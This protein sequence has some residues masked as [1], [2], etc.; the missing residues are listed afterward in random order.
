MSDPKKKIGQRFVVSHRRSHHL[1]QKSGLQGREVFE[2]KF[3]SLQSVVDIL[4]DQV[5]GQDGGRRIYMVEGDPREIQGKAAELCP[6]TIIEPELPRTVTRSEPLAVH[7]LNTL[8]GPIPVSPGQGA[9]LELRLRCGDAPL[10]GAKVILYLAALQQFGGA[11]STSIGGHTDEEGRVILGYDPA[12]WTPTMAMIQP[13]GDAWGMLVQQQGCTGQTV[14]VPPLPR[15]GPLGWWHLLVGATAY[16]PTLGAGISV[17]VIDTGAGPHP[18]LAHVRRIGAFLDCGSDTSD[19]AGLDVEMH[20][21]HVSGIIGAR[22][23]EGSGDYA[24]LAPGVDLAVARVFKANG[25]ANQGDIAAAVE[26][27]SC[28]HQVDLI[29]LSLGGSPSLIERDALT[30][31][32]MKGT[33]CIAAAGNKHGAPV[34][35]PAAYPECVAVS[36]VELHGFAPTGTLASMNL[37]Q[38]PDRFSPYGAYLAAFSN[39]GPQIEITAPGGGILSTAP[40]KPDQAQAPYVDMSGTSMASP[41]V[42]AA[43]AVLLSEDPM[44]RSLPRGLARATY[45]RSILFANAITLGLNPYYQGVGLVRQLRAGGWGQ[46]GQWAVAPPPPA[47]QGAGVEAAEPPPPAPTAGTRRFILAPKSGANALPAEVLLERIG[48][49]PGVSVVRRQ[50]ERVLVDATEEGLRALHRELGA[51]FFIEEDSPRHLAP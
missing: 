44:Y 37:P 14:Q 26:A 39:L 9:R 15:K 22:P 47:A 17:G 11:Q 46:Q 16:K 49:I 41:L 4:S 12:T 36:A 32:L 40:A 50:R 34:M 30:V 25:S 35:S 8:Q 18:Y 38:A 6:D 42:T 2:Q 13:A 45:A 28:D 20:G 23:L 29:N 24:G 7:F 51:E 21:T 43:L 10:R 48:R 3:S 1:A 33:L 27:L 19:A 31:A 5:V